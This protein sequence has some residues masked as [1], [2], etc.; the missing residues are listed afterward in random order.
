MESDPIRDEQEIRDILAS[1]PQATVSY[2]G[3]DAEAIYRIVG[4]SSGWCANA[5]YG[6]WNFRTSHAHVIS[7]V[8]GAGGS[9]SWTPRISR[10]EAMAK[11]AEWGIEP[12]ALDALREWTKTKE[13][14]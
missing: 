9:A 5:F 7:E 4:S 13:E 3:T 12:D 10:A 14:S 6:R 11:L 8:T 1:R 2:Y